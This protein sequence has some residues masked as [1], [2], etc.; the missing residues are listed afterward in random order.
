MAFITIEEQG[1]NSIDTPT[2]RVLSIQSH[3]VSGYVG[4]KSATFPLQVLGYDVDALNSVHFSNHT[5]YIGSVSVLENVI[6]VV[7]LLKE[8]NPN[9]VYVCDPVMGDSSGFYVPKDLL[10]LFRDELAPLATILT[11]NHFEAEVLTGIKI[12]TNEDAIRAQKVLLDKGIKHVV[13][14]SCRLETNSTQI[15]IYGGSMEGGQVTNHFRIPVNN[16]P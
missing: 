2:R 13:I 8:R 6:K 5:G 16:L 15:W 3:V 7:T 14:T 11:P 12:K 4:N 9:L 1:V 10:P